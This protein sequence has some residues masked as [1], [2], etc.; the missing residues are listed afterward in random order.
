ML[1]LIVVVKVI[2]VVCQNELPH[3]RL[4]SMCNDSR[5]IEINIDQLK[6]NIIV[7]YVISYSWI[8]TNLES[9]FITNKYLN[10]FYE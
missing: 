8:L 6:F 3:L 4:I 1:S 7:K 5:A 2:V 10:S 9:R